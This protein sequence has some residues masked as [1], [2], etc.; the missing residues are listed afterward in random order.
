MALRSLQ[1]LR[2]STVSSSVF[3]GPVSDRLLTAKMGPCLLFS[4][5][6]DFLNTLVGQCLLPV[7]SP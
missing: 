7:S 2:G 6:Q 5:P 4:V 1:A 3:C